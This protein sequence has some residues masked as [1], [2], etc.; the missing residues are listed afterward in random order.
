MIILIRLRVNDNRMIEPDLPGEFHVVFHR[1]GTGLVSCAVV[2]E[3]VRIVGEQ[4]NMR[5]DQ[6][7]LRARSPRPGSQNRARHPLSSGNHT[8]VRNP[9]AD[10]IEAFADRC[11]R[12]RFLAWR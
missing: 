7:P 11:L 2:R 4:V 10:Q 3:P 6:Y 5:F 8:P 9:T 12:G 1:R